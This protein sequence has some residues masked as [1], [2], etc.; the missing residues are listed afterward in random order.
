M[1]LVDLRRDS[2]SA[3]QVEALLRACDAAF[4]P[5]LSRR[6]ALGAYAAKLAGQARLL[7]A[8]QDEA[9]IG[10]VAIYCNDPGG[11]AYVS[12]VSVAPGHARRGI[13]GRLLHE[14]LDVALRSGMREAALEVGTDN[15][16]AVAL[17]RK[18]GFAED[19]EANQDRMLRMRLPLLLERP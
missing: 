18:H 1:N 12:N 10:L 4:V 14:A 16:A 19:G 5:P 11:V 6:V 15:A 9:L 2:A 13:A 17:Y 3:A 7:E 8:W